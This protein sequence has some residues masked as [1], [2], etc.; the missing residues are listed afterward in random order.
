MQ[1]VLE[2]LTAP[3]EDEDITGLSFERTTPRFVEPDTEDN[4][5]RLFEENRWTDMLPIVLPTEARVQAMLKGTS[6][7]PDKI[8]GRLR[9]TVFREA[10][11]FDVEKVAVNAV[12]A[13]AR[14]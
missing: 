7:P 8:V 12:M 2:G 6:H 13:G 11:E 14:P 4:L 3:L 5:H 10:W 9:P 1:E